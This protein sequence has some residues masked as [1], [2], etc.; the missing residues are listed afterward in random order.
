MCD[1]DCIA[2]SGPDVCP[3]LSGSMP[4]HG[5]WCSE[6]RRWCYGNPY[7]PSGRAGLH[8]LDSTRRNSQTNGTG[9]SSDTKGCSCRSHDIERKRPE[10][11]RPEREFRVRVIEISRLPGRLRVTGHA[12]VAEPT[13]GMVGIGSR[14]ECARMAIPARHAKAPVLVALVA[15]VARNGLVRPRQGDR[16]LSNG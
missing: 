12:V 1:T 2:S 15:L 3:K 13:G 4:H 10:Y 5:S 16:P 14:V 7:N 6:S 8:G 11:A 9:N